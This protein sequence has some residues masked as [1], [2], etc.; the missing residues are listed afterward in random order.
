VAPAV[1]RCEAGDL[2]LGGGLEV[3]LHAVLE[4]SAPGEEIEVEV[5]S[6]ATALELPAWARLAGHQVVDGPAEIPG[7][8][9]RCRVR[10]RRGSALRVLA[11]PLGEPRRG[12][13]RRGGQLRTAD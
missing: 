4:P 3:L 12:L 7:G 10:L 2:E 5:R 6:R 1:R 8:R 13:E 11:P 9:G